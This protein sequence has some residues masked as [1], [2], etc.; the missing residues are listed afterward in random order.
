MKSCPHCHRMPLSVICACRY[1]YNEVD[2]LP[3]WVLFAV[4]AG[5]FILGTIVGF[6]LAV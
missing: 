3:T 1:C 4:P 2:P 5:A 6:G